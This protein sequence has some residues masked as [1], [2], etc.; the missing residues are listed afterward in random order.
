MF[1]LCLISFVIT[2]ISSSVS[3]QLT[4]EQMPILIQLSLVK[5]RAGKQNLLDGSLPRKKVMLTQTLI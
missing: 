4:L 5:S 1:A 2:L 3:Y